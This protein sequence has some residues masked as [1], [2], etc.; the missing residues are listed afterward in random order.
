MGSKRKVKCIET[1]V[2]YNST[3]EAA[4]A[5]GHKESSSIRACCNGK[6]DTAG[7][8]HWE[9]YEEA[10]LPGEVWRYARYFSNN[11]LY[12]FDDKYKCSNMGRIKRSD[13]NHILTGS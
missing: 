2:I 5:I 4:K 12:D 8:Y 1:N 10:D 13:N 11:T 9:Y 7:G 3:L 6:Y